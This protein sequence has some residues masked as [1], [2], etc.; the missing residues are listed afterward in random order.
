MGRA[1]RNPSSIHPID[2]GRWVSLRSTY[3][4]VLTARADPPDRPRSLPSGPCG[5]EAGRTRVGEMAPD[6]HRQHA[7]R[8]DAVGRMAGR[9]GEGRIG[10]REH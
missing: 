10:G 4:C 9:P 2:I 7:H 6:T 1:Q 8:T 3:P 5:G